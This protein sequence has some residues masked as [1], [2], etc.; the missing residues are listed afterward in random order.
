[1]A[2][3][4]P[5]GPSRELASG[6]TA[7]APAPEPEGRGRRD[8]LRETHT[9]HPSLLTTV[10]SEHGLRRRLEPAATYDAWRWPPCCASTADIPHEM[11][12]RGSD[13]NM[14]A[15]REDLAAYH[16]RALIFWLERGLRTGALR[17]GDEPAGQLTF[18]P[19]HAS[20]RAPGAVEQVRAA[21]EAE[22]RQGWVDRLGTAHNAEELRELLVPLGFSW[23]IVA[24]LSTVPKGDSIRVFHDTSFPK[25]RRGRLARAPLSANARVGV[26]AEM[27]QPGP[28]LFRAAVRRLRA[29]WP[30]RRLRA[31]KLD[32]VAAYRRLRY[33][34]SERS[35]LFEF[36]D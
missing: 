26:N 21:V 29:R 34:G 23:V 30:G 11:C 10:C 25:R 13:L 12:G 20:A 8:L 3:E 7:G 1:V 28:R 18:W 5:E 6:W 24:P 27:S 14:A 4:G 35:L 9:A 36:A 33:D 15:V 32:V 31:M 19:N 22:A 2:F 16:D 17:S